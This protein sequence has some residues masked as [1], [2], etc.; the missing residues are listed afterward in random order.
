[1]VEQT[2]KP[3]EDV[4]VASD[5]PVHPHSVFFEDDGETAYFYALDLSRS[6]DMIVDAV[7]I[8]NVTNV[9]DRGRPST[10][11]M[12]WSV[13]GLK[14]ALLI[15]GF[16]HAVFDFSIKRGFCRTNFPNFQTTPQGCWPSSDHSWSDDAIAWLK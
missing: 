13:D 3:G 11:S 2:F 5:S 12:E 15:N 9:T 14:C 10:L 8:Y 7:H 16:P 1:M 6:D 4:N